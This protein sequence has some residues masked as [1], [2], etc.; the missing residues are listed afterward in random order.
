LKSNVWRS[1]IALFCS[2]IFLS[3]CVQNKE[4][5]ILKSVYDQS[6]SKDPII[7]KSFRSSIPEKVYYLTRSGIEEKLSL[8]SH[9]NSIHLIW[10]KNFYLRN[11]GFYSYRNKKWQGTNS[12]ES[13]SWS[14]QKL[15]IIPNANITKEILILEVLMEDPIFGLISYPIIFRENGSICYDY[16]LKLDFNL[17]KDISMRNTFQLDSDQN[18]LK[19]Y[20]GEGKLSSI[21]ISKEEILNC[22]G[23]GK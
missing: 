17:G 9:H 11:P 15:K 18:S 22:F 16:L 2:L 1:I 5:E 3:N 14:I 6:E 7:I 23:N 10:S 13:E 21:Q 19:F 4:S 8:V 20:D 12:L